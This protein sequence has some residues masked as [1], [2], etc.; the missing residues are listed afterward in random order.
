MSKRTPALDWYFDVISPYAFLQCRRLDDLP[1]GVELTLRPV[2]FAALLDHWGQLGPAEIPPKRL[3]TSR[4]VA[5]LA[6]RH[7]VKMQPPAFHPFNPLPLLRLA[8]AAG[9]GREAV[10][11]LFDFVWV[12]RGDPRDAEALAALG[13]RIGVADPAAAMADPAVKRALV[14]NGERAIAAG[15]FGVPSFAAGDVVLWGQD[16]IEM[17]HDWVAREGGGDGLPRWL[18]SGPLEGLDAAAVRR[19]KAG[20]T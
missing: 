11:A 5:W 3:F 9:A 14:E 7:G 17:I 2:L 18:A 19:P 4:H 15:V 20:T 16:A 10:S 6:R 1:A 13:R 8:I 12:E